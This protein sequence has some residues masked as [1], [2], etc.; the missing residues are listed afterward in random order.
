MGTVRNRALLGAFLLAVA[1]CAGASGPEGIE[2]PTSTAGVAPSTVPPSMPPVTTTPQPPACDAQTPRAEVGTALAFFAIC[3]RGEI[4]NLYPVFRPAR[5]EFSLLRSLELLVAGTRESE[6]AMGLVT[7]FD[8][9]DDADAITMIV[10]LD[11]DGVLTVDFRLGDNRWDPRSL[12]ATSTQLLSFLRP[13][14]ATVFA[15]PEVSALD[16]STLC[17]G[18]A[19]CEGVTTR[20][21]WRAQMFL[22]EGVLFHRG[23]SLLFA[24]ESS[25]CRV[26]EVA[27]RTQATV[28]NVTEDDML[29]LRA[30]A[31]VAYPEIGA[32]APGAGVEVLE[33]SDVADDGGLWRLVRSE[34][35]VVGW[36]NSAYLQLERTEEE[37]LMDLFVA[38]ARSPT[39][40]TFDAMPLTDEVALGLGPTL[41]KEVK[42]ESL[43]DPTEWELNVEE[44]RAYVGGFSALRNL[45]SLD[46][47]VV[48]VGPHPHCAS[49]PMDAPVGYEAMKRVS[50]QPVLGRNDSCLMWFT[51]DL[52]VDDSGEVAAI[53]LDLWEP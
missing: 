13:L 14:H 33:A 23:C 11:T 10:D 42:A 26:A 8:W 2:T 47:Y 15:F 27:V 32:L 17:W 46:D 28:V 16:N 5:T 9:V 31:G 40:E 7:G 50:V 52:F 41:L 51:V 3:G 37:A 19:S 38:F 24:T 44:F 53:T 25:G 22:N 6:R 48:T 12:A 35:G 43:A 45:E 30:G 39:E 49:G 29:N 18:E 21:N 4:G 1:A 36:V 34:K 20:E